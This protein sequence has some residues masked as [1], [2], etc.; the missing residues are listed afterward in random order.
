MALGFCVFWV[1]SGVVLGALCNCD[2][3]VFGWLLVFWGFSILRTF[4][5]TLVFGVF[6]GLDVL[7]ELLVRCVLGDNVWGLAACGLPLL[8]FDWFVLRAVGW[9]AWLCWC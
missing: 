5:F 4:G 8:C 7:G 3:G 6:L 9:F 2:L 1:F